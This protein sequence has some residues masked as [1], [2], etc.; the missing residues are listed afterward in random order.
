MQEVADVRDVCF[1]HLFFLPGFNFAS[2]SSSS[3]STVPY[4]SLYML[5]ITSEKVIFPRFMD[6]SASYASSVTETVFATKIDF[7]VNVINVSIIK[8][9]FFIKFSVNIEY[10]NT[11]IFIKNITDVK[12][13]KI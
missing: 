4:R 1:C 7:I 2:F 8:N 11:I 13:I 5:M 12:H 3:S 10:T 6:T 9:K